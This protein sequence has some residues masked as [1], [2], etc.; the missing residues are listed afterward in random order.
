MNMLS[1]IFKNTAYQQIFENDGV[2]KIP[3]LEASELNTL[4]D[5]WLSIQSAKYFY[6]DDQYHV[7]LLSHNKEYK[8][9]ISELLYPLFDR[10]QKITV[11]HY[12][13]L[14]TN[15]IIKYAWSGEVP[16]HQNWTFVDEQKYTSLTIW[17]PLQDVDET[18]GA[19]YFL[20][21]SHRLFRDMYRG[22]NIPYF[23]IQYESDI[24]DRLVSIPMKAG[25][26]LI[27]DDSMLHYSPRNNTG[28]H[29]IAIQSNIVPEGSEIFY[30][31]FK[32]GLFRDSI[33]KI[34]IEDEQ[35]LQ[36]TAWGKI[37]EQCNS[38]TFLRPIEINRSQF[39]NRLKT[40]HV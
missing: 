30:H 29:R 24:K 37:K 25:E 19:L 9:K 23:F 12:R 18:N 20:K 32:R 10:L 7:T 5:A 1:K 13:V 16:L 4:K 39:L 38:K 33:Q 3:F 36:D 22:P 21:G 17:C 15:L 6:P 31:E 8:N 2:L 11:D 35:L 27:F 34:K 40:I 28:E 14:T 26:A